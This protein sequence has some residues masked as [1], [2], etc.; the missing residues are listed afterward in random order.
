MMI[1]TII[2]RTATVT[3]KVTLKKLL[4]DNDDDVST[5]KLFCLLFDTVECYRQ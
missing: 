5:F 1:M 2:A 4:L 3:V